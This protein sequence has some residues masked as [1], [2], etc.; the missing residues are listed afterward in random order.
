MSFIE[1]YATKTTS[2]AMYDVYR[3]LEY[4][5]SDDRGRLHAFL[6]EQIDSK[7]SEENTQ[8]LINVL[9]CARLCGELHRSWLSTNGL[10]LIERL[11]KLAHQ[12]TTPSDLST[13]L[14][15]IVANTMEEI[16]RSSTELY[17][18][19]DRAIERESTNFDIKLY[20]YKLALQF[21]CLPIMKDLFERLE[22]K[23]IQFYSLGYLLTDHYLR[24]HTNYR[25]IRNFF[26]YLIN[27][28]LVYGDDSWNQIM[29]CYKYGNFLRINEI[30]TFSDCYLSYSLIYMQSLLGTIIVDLIQNGNRYTTIGNIFKYQYDRVLFEKKQTLNYTLRSLFYQTDSD[31]SLKLQDTRDFDVWPKI[32]YQF[33]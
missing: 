18:L 27:L 32:D 31:E 24:I 29:F 10:A 5:S 8:Y 33:V 4:L 3:A 20:L 23:N 2:L 30:R 12:P 13:E 1:T 22:I 11:L 21:N 14:L 19:L 9:C 7:T 6:V 25:H 26:H 28:V 17:C 15:I 16:G